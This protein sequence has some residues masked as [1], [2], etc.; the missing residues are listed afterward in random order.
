MTR[1]AQKLL[2]ST[3]PM[4]HPLLASHYDDI[5][6]L[7]LDALGVLALLLGVLLSAFRAVP[8]AMAANFCGIIC[9]VVGCVEIR[10]AIVAPPHYSLE[11]RRDDFIFGCIVLA[12]GGLLIGR[13][14]RWLRR[15]CS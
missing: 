3:A 10:A 7:P 13:N 9:A 8:A 14:V 4:I 1:I 15:K 11:A 5:E 12:F 6:L 2:Y